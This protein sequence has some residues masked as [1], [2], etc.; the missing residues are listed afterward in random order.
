MRKTAL[1]VGFTGQDGQILWKYL[2]NLGYNLIGI[3]TNKII[4][5]YY[6]LNHSNFNISSE[7]DI[8]SLISTIYIDEI[9]FLAAVH[10]S[11][12]DVLD[13]E[14]D[15]FR[16]SNEVNFVSPSTILSCIFNYSKKTKFFYASSSHIFRG[17][18]QTPQNEETKPVPLCIYGITKT[19]GTYITQYFANKGVFASVGILYNHESIFRDRKFVSQ[20]II[21]GAVAIKK[22]LL[23]SLTLGS[24]DAKIDWGYAPDFVKAYHMILN[25]SKPDTFIISTYKLTSIADFVE[26][27]FNQLGLDWRKYIKID[28]E[29]IKKGL[30]NNLLGDH[31]KLK[32]MTGWYPETTFSEMIKILLDYELSNNG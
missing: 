6:S 1:I 25:I 7:S 30:Q 14:L 23:D 29:I 3:S 16:K 26:E 17:S 8:K 18:V 15:Y 12:T 31:S 10:Q 11:S 19:S 27:T 24:L 32:N 20:K 21:K 2:E 13:N 4:S 9:Y 5:N 28:S 22:G